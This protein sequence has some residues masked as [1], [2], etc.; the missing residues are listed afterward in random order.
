MKFQRNEQ[1]LQKNV[2]QMTRVTKIVT[3]FPENNVTRFPENMTSYSENVT[4]FLKIVTWF[5]KN[6]NWFPKIS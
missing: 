5:P 2:P 3:S 6:M 4:G 1:K